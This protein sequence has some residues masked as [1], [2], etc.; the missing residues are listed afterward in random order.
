MKAG[1]GNMERGAA[2]EAKERVAVVRRVLPDG[3]AVLRGFV[4]DPIDGEVRSVFAFGCLEDAEEFVAETEGLGLANGWRAMMVPVEDLSAICE[5]CDA[6]H[7]SV[8]FG[9]GIE[10]EVLGGACLGHDRGS[11]KVGLERRVGEVGLE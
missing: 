9:V 2:S 6:A 11:E 8:P 3:V 7:I 4:N 1:V 5:M 10:A